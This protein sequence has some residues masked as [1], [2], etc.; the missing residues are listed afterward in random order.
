[1]DNEHSGG[2]AER[3]NDIDNSQSCVWET[4]DNEDARSVASNASSR[5]SVST[6]ER[7]VRMAALVEE[8]KFSAGQAELE[9][10]QAELE[11]SQLELQRSQIELQR[12]RKQLEL[13]KEIAVART[14]LQ[15]FEEYENASM[16]ENTVR[17]PSES[18]NHRDRNETIG[19]PVGHP[20]SSATIE[21]TSSGV[22]PSCQLKHLRHNEKQKPV[23]HGDSRHNVLVKPSAG[24]DQGSDSMFGIRRVVDSLNETLKQSQLPKLELNGVRR[25]FVRIPT[26]V[27]LFRKIDRIEHSG[28]GTKITILDA[29]HGRRRTHT[30]IRVFT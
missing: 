18:I 27:A 20:Q 14:E 3:G 19:A 6:M 22:Q 24:C 26:V 10:Y 16:D 7:R 15:I 17:L 2:S 25:R 4:R 30:G 1:M 28:T 8:R 21:T 12:Q 11:R 29:V 23:C 13:D 5:H 9:R